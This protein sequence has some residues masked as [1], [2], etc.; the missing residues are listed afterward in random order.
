[1]T[2]AKIRE[3]FDAKIANWRGRGAPPTWE[4]FLA[5]RRGRETRKA[6]R[7]AGAVV[8]HVGGAGGAVAPAPA[9]A[10]R[11]RRAVAAVVAPSPMADLVWRLMSEAD[12]ECS[13][14]REQMT[15]ATLHITECGHT[16]CVGCCS[17]FQ[18]AECATCRAVIVRPPIPVAP[19]A[20]LLLENI[21]LPDLPLAIVEDEELPELDDGAEEIDEE[22]FSS[23][24]SIPEEE[25]EEEDA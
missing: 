5:R 6:E 13:V 1:M 20:V 23:S 21:I 24:S 11:G 9:P 7:N 12:K 10:R 3:K 22:P 8:A 19:P 25:E 18:R 2:E 16:F 15:R 14:C 4:V 17:R